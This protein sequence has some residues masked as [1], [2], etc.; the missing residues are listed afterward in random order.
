MNEEGRESTLDLIED[1]VDQM[2]ENR[3]S[4]KDPAEYWDW[5]GLSL[6]MSTTFLIPVPVPEELR[7]SIGQESLR[8]NLLEAATRAYRAKV[9]RLSPPIAKQLEQHVTLRTIDEM[10][11]DHLH[12]LDTLRSG[13][14]LRAYGQKDPLLE[15]KAESF[16]LFQLMM[17]RI[18]S[19]AVARFFRFELVQTPPEATAAMSGGTAQKAQASAYAAA[20][21]QQGGAASASAIGTMNPEGGASQPS[22][23]VVRDQ[24]KV[25]RNDPCPCGSGKKYKKCHGRKA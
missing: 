8:E 20:S 2:I 18:R 25:G 7:D 12:E 16:E 3:T 17:E 21:A 23:P 11:K 14:G 10:W 19:E 9:E 4:S 13:I 5:A 1:T 22:A 15:Y 6:D 24:P